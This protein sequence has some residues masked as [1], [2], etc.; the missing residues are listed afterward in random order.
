VNERVPV[1]F[2][3]DE[4]E[5]TLVIESQ[6]G[7]LPA[8]DPGPVLELL[9]RGNRLGDE[10]LGG[11]LALGPDNQILLMRELA[12][13]RLPFAT[14]ERALSEQVEAAQGWQSRLEGT[15]AAEPDERSVPRHELFDPSRL[16]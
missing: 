2:H 15:P 14:L 16:A 6:V 9:A 13:A 8:R 1:A 11:T 4:A 7:Q 3:Y 5:Q 10:T 12:N